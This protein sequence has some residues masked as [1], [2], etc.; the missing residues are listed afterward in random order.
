MKNHDVDTSLA[1]TDKSERGF[2]G[3][4]SQLQELLMEPVKFQSAG[5]MPEGFPDL[6]IV[7]MEDEK[8]D[9]AGEKP[10]PWQR[11]D[12]RGEE[13]VNWVDGL[14]KGGEMT[15]A[16][17]RVGEA[18]ATLRQNEIN[19]AKKALEHTTVEQ[20]QKYFDDNFD[21]ISKGD[22]GISANDLGDA[23]TN[24]KNAEERA[25]VLYMAA[26]FEKAKYAH[27]D[28][29]PDS[30]QDVGKNDVENLTKIKDMP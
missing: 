24:A 23:L 28:V 12:Y 10:K 18:L 7:G 11:D 14:Q 4:S 8:T 16:E 5:K 6:Q 20:V 21:K 15:T 26:N 9:R 13:E 19:D 2:Q 22:G 17:K 27:D 1:P 3:A 30:W 29:G 25:M